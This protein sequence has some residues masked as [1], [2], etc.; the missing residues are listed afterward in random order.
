MIVEEKSLRLHQQILHTIYAA[1]KPLGA[2]ALAVALQ[3]EGIYVSS[4]T[5]GRLLGELEEQKYL[6]QVSNKGRVLS[7][8]GKA[9]L[10]DL[11]EQEHLQGLAFQL[12]QEIRRGNSEEMIGVLVARRA[13]ERETCRLAAVHATEREAEEIVTFAEILEQGES[14]SERH[15]AVMDHKFH[16][17]IAAASRNAVLLAALRLIH[18]GPS[19]WRPLANVRNDE[20]YSIRGDHLA[21]AQAVMRRN[22]DQ[23]ERALL[24]HLDKIIDAARNMDYEIF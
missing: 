11:E 6:V 20:R 15:A 5:A 10:E 23:A 21:I 8:Q 9:F 12:L 4:A 2:S 19:F 22:P 13:I 24:D 17:A 3:G 16:E 7:E 1:R 14:F 18:R